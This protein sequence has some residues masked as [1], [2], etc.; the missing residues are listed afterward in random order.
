MANTNQ[1]KSQAAQQLVGTEE[2]FAD[3]RA[4]DWLSLQFGVD[5][6]DSIGDDHGGRARTAGF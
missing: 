4:F 5:S 3:S 2:V 6:R 1:T